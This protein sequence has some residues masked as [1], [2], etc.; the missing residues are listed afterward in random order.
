VWVLLTQGRGQTL[1]SSG[2]RHFEPPAGTG[3]SMPDCLAGYLA[4]LGPVAGRLRGGSLECRDALETITRYGRH[5]Q[6]CIY[7]DPPYLAT[8]RSS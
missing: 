5:E 7:A 8:T 4:Q 6:V 1:R 3:T 2:W